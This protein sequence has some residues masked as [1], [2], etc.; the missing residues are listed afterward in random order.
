MNTENGHISILVL[1]LYRWIGSAPRI[2]YPLGHTN[3]TCLWY[4][5]AL[6]ISFS[7]EIN[8][9]QIILWDKAAG[10]ISDND[11]SMY[12]YRLILPNKSLADKNPSSHSDESII[13]E[14]R[15]RNT[16]FQ[17]PT[18]SEYAS[19]PHFEGN[20]NASL[21]RDSYWLYISDTLLATMDYFGYETDQS[22]Q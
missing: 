19:E 8:M 7:K 1:P 17:I 18:L 9:S 6:L 13:C 20:Y 4:N 2:K 15:N 22:I 3:L 10:E 14:H 5:I 21:L 12:S 11:S 16:F